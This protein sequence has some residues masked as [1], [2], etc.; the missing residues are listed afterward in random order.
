MRRGA[1]VALALGE[2]TNH[3]A[4][5]RLLAAVAAIAAPGAGACSL[6]FAACVRDSCFVA[7]TLVSTPNGPRAIEALRVGD[8]VWSYA[9]AERSPVVRSIAAVHRSLVREARSIEL[10]DGGAIRGVTPSHPVFSPEAGLY[11][12]VSRLVRGHVVATYQSGA[13]PALATVS[14]IV[15]TE[16]AVPAIE[17]F[18]LSVAGHDQ[19]YFADGVLVHN[20]SYPAR[21]CTAEEVQI[22]LATVDPQAGLYAVRVAVSEPKGDGG[23]SDFDFFVA[24]GGDVHCDTPLNTTANGWT[25]A[26]KPLPAGEHE[27]YVHGYASTRGGTCTFQ[28]TLNVSGAVDGGGLDASG[29]ASRDADASRE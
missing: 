14:R 11:V 21:S 16:T 22:E 23:T 4:T 25:C 13:E 1:T 19:N 7:G 29:D 12:P 10:D 27:L 20:K 2:M 9:F 28:R 5:R 18:N 6:L 26:L 15:A 3:G 8:L 24:E 17:V